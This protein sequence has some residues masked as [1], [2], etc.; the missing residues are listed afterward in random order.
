MLQLEGHVS[1]SLS[2]PYCSIASNDGNNATGGSPC[3]LY[4]DTVILQLTGPPLWPEEGGRDCNT[5]S[6]WFSVVLPSRFAFVE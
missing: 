6:W 4:T 3:T 1:P 5:A 2:F